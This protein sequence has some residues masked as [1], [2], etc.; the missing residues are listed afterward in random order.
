[1][2]KEGVSKPSHVEDEYFV[3]EEA[4]KLRR[5]ARQSLKE[6][7]IEEQRRLRELHFMHCPKCGQSLHE[8]RLGVA[9]VDVCFSCNGMF[10]DRADLEHV[11]AREPKGVV[12]AILNWF[13]E[14]T[15]KP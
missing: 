3:K 5:L 14:E 12:S 7:T 2:S 8:M 10:L 9:T 15:K 11:A 1:M 13:K 4:E 6:S